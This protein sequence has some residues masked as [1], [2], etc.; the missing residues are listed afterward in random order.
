[1]FTVYVLVGDTSYHIALADCPIGAFTIRGSLADIKAVA[2]TKDVHQI[3]AVDHRQSFPFPFPAIQ[4]NDDQCYFSNDV[5]KP[6]V[7]GNA[8]ASARSAG[9]RLELTWLSSFD[10]RARDHP[11]GRTVR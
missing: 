9:T 7:P 11:D 10:N 5:P 4:M 2:I 6:F 8:P 1:M 3:L